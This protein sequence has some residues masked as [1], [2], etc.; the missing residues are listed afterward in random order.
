MLE[1]V[2]FAGL[3][4]AILLTILVLWISH[5][6]YYQQTTKAVNVALDN[7][8][9]CENDCPLIIDDNIPLPPLTQNFSY[10]LAILCADLV[11]RVELPFRTIDR[12]V[13]DDIINPTLFGKKIGILE[14]DNQ[15]I[16]VV[17]AKDDIA[18]VS[19]RGTST[20]KEW[21][22]DFKFMQREVDHNNDGKGENESS[23][24]FNDLQCH[25]G[26][27]SVYESFSAHLIK[28]TKPYSSI[29]FCGH[30]L[31]SALATL[32]SLDLSQS[33]YLYVFGT[34]RVCEYIPNKSNIKAFFR[35]NNTCDVV[36]QVPL[37]VMW[38]KK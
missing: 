38:N 16:G 29:V 3:F 7:N 13:S 14:Y 35:I 17:W 11:A 5:A 2:I 12:P 34:P 10:P 21:S 9:F 28:L 1:I 22:K 30:S 26:F 20:E 19:F 23:R 25:S 15:I 6:I 4:A 36:Q 8:I 32:S 18:F 31:G 37:S 33:I 27:L 24:T